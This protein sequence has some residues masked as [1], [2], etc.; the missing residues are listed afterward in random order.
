MQMFLFCQ[1]LAALDQFMLSVA[2]VK[3]VREIL[4][5]YSSIVNFQ[6]KK[7]LLCDFTN[8]YLLVICCKKHC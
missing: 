4:T 5:T 7:F 2:H 1:C 8:K 3:Q 6:S